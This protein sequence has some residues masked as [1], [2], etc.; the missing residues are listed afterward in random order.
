MDTNK[1]DGNHVHNREDENKML[2]MR[3]TWGPPQ[4]QMTIYDN[5][6]DPRK[7]WLTLVKILFKSFMT[8]GKKLYVDFNARE[9]QLRNQV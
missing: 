9:I 2:I 7:R 6:I 4:K 5:E 8:S 1:N 3:L